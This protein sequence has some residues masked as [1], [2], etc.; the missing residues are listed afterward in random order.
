MQDNTALSDA[1]Q[2]VLA[3]APEKSLGATTEKAKGYHADIEA[4]NGSFANLI[5]QT[6]AFL[7]NAE[8]YFTMADGELA[9]YIAA[10]A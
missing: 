3:A 10:R 9:A 6:I 1:L 5:T 8:E 7:S 2:G 4:I